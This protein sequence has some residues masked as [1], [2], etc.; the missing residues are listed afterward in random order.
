MQVS[1]GI[2]GTGKCRADTPIHFLNHMLDVSPSAV[3]APQGPLK[4]LLTACLQ[5]I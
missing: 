1:I 5:H 3:Y 2:D 4:F